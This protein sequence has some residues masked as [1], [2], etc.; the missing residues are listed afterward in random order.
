MQNNHWR[1]FRNDIAI[2]KAFKGH[3]YPPDEPTKEYKIKLLFDK[4]NVL[5]FNSYLS[6][7][8]VKCTKFK[9]VTNSIL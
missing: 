3:S 8:R 4:T 6:K 9:A 5:T 1:L 7:I 2:H